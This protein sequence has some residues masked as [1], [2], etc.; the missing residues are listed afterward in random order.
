M[1]RLY[2]PKVVLAAVGSTKVKETEQALAY[3]FNQIQFHSVLFFTNKENHTDHSSIKYKEIPEIKTLRDYQFFSVNK[4]PQYALPELSD[5]VTHVLFISWDGFV[6][7]PK[8]WDKQFLNYDYI[9][10]PLPNSKTGGNGGFCLKSKKF[11]NQQ[12]NICDDSSLPCGLNEDIILSISLRDQFIKAG[13]KY[14]PY[15]VAK[16]FAVEY[17]KYKASFGF[18]DLD[19]HPQFKPHVK[20]V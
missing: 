9:G 4:L 11:L 5:G 2:L 18:H 1:S 10:A 6:V 16:N 17:D 7:N 20:L 15:S 12:T 13:C 8:A 19:I 14:A 3:S